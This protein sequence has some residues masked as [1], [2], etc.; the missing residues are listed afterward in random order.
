MA[1]RHAAV[2]K[3]LE[4][5]ELDAVVVFGNQLAAHHVRFLTAWPPG[6]DSFV[7]IGR[8]ERPVLLVPSEN[9]L[10]TAIDMAG[11]FV[12]V[13]WVGPETAAS[14][15]RALGCTG[16]GS[17]P[18]TARRVGIV[19]PIPYGTYEHVAAALDGV[20]IVDASPAFGRLRLV[21]RPAEIES[22]RRAAALADRAVEQLLDEVRPGL[23]EYE[24]GAIIERGY[25]QAGGEHGIC[26]L[27][28]TSMRQPDAIVPSQVWSNRRLR[29]GDMVL[30]ELSVGVAGSTSQILRTI[31]IGADPPPA[32]RRLH[33]VADQAF[34]EIAAAVRPGTTAGELL[35]AAGV[36]DEAGLTVVDDVVHGYGG[37]Y[38]PPILRTPATQRRP[39]P[40][41][42]LAPGMMVV[43]Q[44]NVVGRDG[45]VGVQTGELLVVTEDG[46]ERLHSLPMGLL[47]V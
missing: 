18:G 11:A 4:A 21:K 37:G 23:R 15:A 3:L 42:E 10:P 46:H 8:R 16:G 12:D 7:V 5:A 31:A 17:E 40:P 26:F 2:R 39:P 29:A 27:A 34:R 30:F 1:D 41:L 43:V 36:I 45:S 35:A 14:I 24:V 22:T 25:R 19:G 47:S 13:E 38:L 9:H 28:S 20:A 6:W 44:P 32:V 33:D